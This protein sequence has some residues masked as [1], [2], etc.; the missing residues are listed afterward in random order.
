MLRAEYFIDKNGKVKYDDTEDCSDSY[1]NNQFA[2]TWKSY[3]DNIIKTC[4][5]GDYRI[6]A[7][8]DLDIGAGEFSPS[9]K[10]LKYGWQSL[11]DCVSQ[12]NPDYKK[13]K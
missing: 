5:W 10:Y 1:T 13:A 9:D 12:S 3:T 11:R 2:G 8:G 7:S 6:P 4:N